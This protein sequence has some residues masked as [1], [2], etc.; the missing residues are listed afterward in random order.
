MLRS[1]PLPPPRP[2]LQV[3]HRGEW[4]RVRFPRGRTESREAVGESCPGWHGAHARPLRYLPIR[5]SACGAG[6]VLP[7]ERRLTRLQGRQP[8]IG[9]EA[10]RPPS[11]IVCRSSRLSPESRCVSC[12]SDFIEDCE[13]LRTASEAECL[14]LV[15]GALISR[16]KAWCER[17]R[18]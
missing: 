3:R 18:I 10:N 12:G 16:T 14:R 15:R 6:P 13:I 17:C 4:R 11:N 1:D 7:R 8:R 5:L 9:L 2:T